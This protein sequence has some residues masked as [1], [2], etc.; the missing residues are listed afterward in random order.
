MQLQPGRELHSM[1]KRNIDTV[2]DVIN[3]LAD[4]HD[5]NVTVVRD[6][7]EDLRR[8]VFD[9][10][11]GGSCLGVDIYSVLKLEPIKFTAELEG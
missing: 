6:L 3:K 2:S 7:V 4:K 5:L 8:M 10:S 1:N 11:K 9:R